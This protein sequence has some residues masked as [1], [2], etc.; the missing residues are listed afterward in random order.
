MQNKNQ[1]RSFAEL[2]QENRW[3]HAF[4]NGKPKYNSPKSCQSKEQRIAIGSL[5]HADSRVV[6]ETN[7]MDGEA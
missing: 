1:K 5:G 3:T 2:G 6:A 7:E 4:R